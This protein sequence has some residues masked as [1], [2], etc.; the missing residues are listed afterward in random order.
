MK[1]SYMWTLLLRLAGKAGIEK[2]VHADGLRHTLAKEL[3]MEGLPVPVIQRQLGHVSLANSEKYLAHIASVD[4]IKVGQDREPLR[5][6][7]LTVAICFFVM[8]YDDG[9]DSRRKESSKRIDNAPKQ[10]DDCR[11]IRGADQRSRH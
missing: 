10:I 9:H 1:S 8:L 5:G 6:S 2:R 7:P 4:I 11:Q 3:M